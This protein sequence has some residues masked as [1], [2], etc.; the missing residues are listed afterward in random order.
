MPFIHRYLRVVS[1]Y[2]FL[3]PKKR[4]IAPSKNFFCSELFLKS[5]E[6]IY[7][8]SELN[9][10]ISEPINPKLPKL[11]IFRQEYNIC[12]VPKIVNPV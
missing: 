8:S 6:L 7:F 9:F 2:R 4:K 3:L 1:M 12:F 11:P 5:V 10:V